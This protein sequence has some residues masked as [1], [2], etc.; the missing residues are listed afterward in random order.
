M[1]RTLLVSALAALAALALTA[2]A[3]AQQD[4]VALV[5]GERIRVHQ[6]GKQT[7]VGTLAAADSTHL[8]I[9]TSP[10]DTI[11][12]PR[13]TVTGVDRWA[14]TQA[15]TGE[16]ALVGLGVGVVSGAIV[17][18]IACSDGAYGME[19]GDCAVATAGAFGLIGAAAG[20]IIW[21][22]WQTDRWEP[23]VWPTLTI[24]PAGADGKSVAFGV[25]LRF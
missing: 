11:P 7:L 19:A 13:S 2:A 16:G 15:K 23:T 18:A 6:G 21:S 4:T 20:A 10:L 17:G 9:I 5:R 1:K 25:H 3:Q 14:G 24:Q 12:V 8:T 22:R